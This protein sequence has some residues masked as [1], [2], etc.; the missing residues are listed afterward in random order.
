MKAL[1]TVLILLI[2]FSL[3][4]A[5]SWETVKEGEMGLD[6][7]AGHFYD[8]DHGWFVT[9]DGGVMHT[10]TGGDSGGVLREPDDS[11]IDWNDVE[12]ASL[13]IGFVAADDGFLYKTTDGGLTW[14]MIGDTSKYTMDFEGLSAVDENLVFFCGDDSTLLKTEDGG[15]NFTRLDYEFMGEDLDGGVA[16]L[17]ADRGVVIS[18]ANDGHSWYTEDGG[19]NWTYVHL[20]FPPAT[21][22][23]RLYDVSAGGEST[24]VVA[25][26][27][28]TL[29]V[30]HD[31]GKTYTQQAD[32][33]PDFER[34]TSVD[35]LD[36]D[37]IFAAGSEAHIIKSMDGGTSWDTLYTGT[38][39]DVEFVD[40]IDADNGYIFA[41]YGQWF[42]TTDGGQ[43]WNHILSW[44][45]ISFWGIAFPTDDKIFLSSWGGGEMTMSTDGGETWVYPH[46]W[47]T[48]STSNLYECEF[49]D[50]DNGMV[51]GSYGEI[52][53]T[54]NGGEDW[55]MIDNP[56]HQESNKHI[57]ALHYVNSDLVFAG[58]SR[59]YIMKSE[60]GGLNWTLLKNEG[61][62]TV[63]DLWP[64]TDNQIMA[65]SNKGDVY[66]ST[67]ELDSFY[68]TIDLD[69]YMIMRA[70]EFRGEVGIIPASRGAVYRLTTSQMD[71]VE[72]VLTDPEGDDFYDVEFV[73]DS[74]VFVVGENSKIYKSE[75]A[76]LTWTPMVAPVEE[77]TLQKVRYNNGVLWAVG[78]EGVILRY[79]V[80]TGLQDKPHFTV[81]DYQLYQN[82]PNP[83]N[84][85]TT[86]TFN[87]KKAGR[88]T[89]EIYATTGQQVATV[90]DDDMRAGIQKITWNGNNLASGLY[91]YRLESGDFT[92]VK[93]MMLLK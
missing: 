70:V 69:G 47:F 56:M 74:L 1:F 17:D 39:Q 12:F 90:I 8:V 36:D 43:T 38:G 30:S 19:V 88:V 22:S 14:D 93:K 87:L 81:D 37:M 20:D 53:R 60:D 59:G 52:Y 76:G 26:Y 28:Y 32:Y 86:F 54:T 35:V 67:T 13:D 7:N 2:S 63:Y 46:N 78:K 72:E 4:S 91:F 33:T 80:T 24:I 18:D 65:T 23:Q 83:F 66:L 57:N 77:V 64:I 75:D 73:N 5:Q 42:K 89:L 61:S 11:G 48:G 40:F 85:A 6:P 29:F 15:A 44:P 41:N 31:A 84:P 25:G 16:F 55:T 49:I 3:V 79:Q 51:A 92:S 50:A 27:H 9:N 71:T 10:A 68:Q 34:F 62:G 82:Y 45:N 21:L 58:G